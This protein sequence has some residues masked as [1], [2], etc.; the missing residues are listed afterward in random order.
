MATTA[1]KNAGAIVLGAF[2]TC[3]IVAKDEALDAADNVIGLSRLNDMLKGWQLTGLRLYTRDTGSISLT[4]ATASY[5]VTGR[6]LHLETVRYKPSG[7]TE[8]P[9][10][11][12][13]SVGYDELPDKA[14]AGIPTQFFYD[15]ARE[16]GTLYV[17]PVLATAASATLEYTATREVADIENSSD[18][19]DAPAEW[20]ETIRYGLAARLCDEYDV[21]EPKAS[22]IAGQAQ[23]FYEI[24]MAGER[25]D[26]FYIMPD[27]S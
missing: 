10:L 5:A 18:A 4:D 21:P 6:P 24:A 27:Y 7:G 25:E 11:R 8:T 17:W 15:R 23:H 19:V 2:Q 22:K 9:M 12:M 1:T 26:S 14:T 3:G 13:S 16:A 20:Y